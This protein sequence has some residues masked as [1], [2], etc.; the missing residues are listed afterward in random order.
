MRNR[1]LLTVLAGFALLT[2]CSEHSPAPAPGPATQPPA[3]AAEPAPAVPKSADDALA[4]RDARLTVT[5]V[6]LEHLPGIDRVVYE[7]GG[8][9]VPGWQVQYT[10]QPLQDG[11]DTAVPVAGK[12]VLEV[13]IL[14]SAYPWDSG[15][16]EYDGPDPVTDAGVPG[17]AGVYGTQ[18][19][20]GVTQSFIGVQGDRPAY[21][22]SGEPTRLVIDIATT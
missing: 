10:G 12:S 17:I 8:A 5:G 9:G 4:S 21:T 2:G 1:L 18:V 14:G 15:V 19:Y 7:L 16:D 20:E 13:R 22:V 6:R 3:S 11:S